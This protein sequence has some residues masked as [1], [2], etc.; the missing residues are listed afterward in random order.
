MIT[1]YHEGGLLYC[2]CTLSISNTPRS[3]D[4]ASEC[5]WHPAIYSHVSALLRRWVA[6]PSHSD[7]LLSLQDPT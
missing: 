4:Q 6:L 5:S 3:I 1:T 7:S 2:A